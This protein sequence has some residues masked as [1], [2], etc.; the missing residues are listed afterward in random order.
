MKIKTGYHKLRLVE[1][2]ILEPE[3][4]TAEEWATLCKICDLP[5]GPTERIVL[6]IDLMEFFE[7]QEEPAGDSG[8]TFIVTEMCPHCGSEIEMRWNTDTMGFKAFC[9]VCGK[10]LMLCDECRHSETPG[11]CDYNS[12]TDSCQHNPPMPPALAP[13][14][15]SAITLR[16]ETPLGA[17]IARATTDPDHPGIYIDLRRTDATDDMPLALVEFSADD[18]DYPAGEPHI[19]SR[20]WGDSQDESYTQRV[21]HRNVEE[22]FATEEVP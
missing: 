1:P 13:R 7:N 11:P 6:H 9:P 22:Y 21:V 14:E 12:R 20:I 16:T 2:L 5:V 8:R 10:R 19:I 3:D 4:W 15:V 17:I 18:A